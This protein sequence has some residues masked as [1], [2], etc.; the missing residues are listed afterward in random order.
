MNQREPYGI[1]YTILPTRPSG[2]S[3]YDWTPYTCNTQNANIDEVAPTHATSSTPPSPQP[4][5]HGTHQ[6][7]R[8]TLW[9]RLVVPER[10]MVEEERLE[11]ERDS[12]T[13]LD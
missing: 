8:H 9:I 3:T 12:H 1:P 10:V 5:P 6:R 2:R 11:E 7:P 13:R 4:S